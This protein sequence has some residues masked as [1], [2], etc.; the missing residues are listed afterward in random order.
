MFDY[1][2]FIKYSVRLVKL[3]HEWK[4]EQE[5]VSSPDCEAVTRTHRG[6]SLHEIIIKP[7]FD[8]PSVC[9]SVKPT[10]PHIAPD[11]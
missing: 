8:T 3:K 6:A 11:P 1:Q 5:G 10:T 9:Y 7:N 4:K 2:I